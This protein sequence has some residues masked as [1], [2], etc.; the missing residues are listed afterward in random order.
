MGSTRLNLPAFVLPLLPLAAPMQQL[1]QALQLLQPPAQSCSLEG[2]P[3]PPSWLSLRECQRSLAVTMDG[4]QIPYGWSQPGDQGILF[5][6]CDDNYALGQDHYVYTPSGVYHFLLKTH[7]DYKG[8]M[9]PTQFRLRIGDQS[10][11]FVGNIAGAMGVLYDASGK[12]L[13]Q[14][15]YDPADL[16]YNATKKKPVLDFYH[17]V[18]TGS[19]APGSAVIARVPDPERLEKAERCIR[20]EV[21]KRGA[22]LADTFKVRFAAWK[23]TEATRKEKLA[24]LENVL[25]HPACSADPEISK[26]FEAILRDARGTT[27]PSA[28]SPAQTGRQ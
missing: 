24:F 6:N 1:D 12:A 17:K 19:S 23:T 10:Y 3:S 11:Y 2:A 22:D 8:G 27:D 5:I 25:R 28:Q 7:R 18:L 16:T 21:S 15:Q 13:D 9:E 4:R 26:E 20:R 14:N